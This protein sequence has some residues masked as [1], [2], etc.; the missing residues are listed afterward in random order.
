MIEKQLKT[1]KKA[2]FINLGKKK[3]KKEWRVVRDGNTDVQR[4]S[5]G[6]RWKFS[7]LTTSRRTQRGTKGGRETLTG[8]RVTED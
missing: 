3:Q 8:R 1:S 5:S 7:V 6:K 2:S 4:D